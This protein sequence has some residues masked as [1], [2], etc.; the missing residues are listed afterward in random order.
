MSAVFHQAFPSC[1]ISAGISG[2]DP[3]CPPEDP[4]FY[5][6]VPIFQQSLN[7]PQTEEEV[8]SCCLD[9]CAEMGSYL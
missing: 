1:C 7:F 5:T 6:N 3:C 2:L 8:V 4:G 9:S